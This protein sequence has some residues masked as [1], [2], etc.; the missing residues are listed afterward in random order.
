[1]K[2]IL[3]HRLPGLVR[4]SKH[5]LALL[6]LATLLPFAFFPF[7]CHAQGVITT[8]AGSRFIGFAGDG[9][10]A[11]SALLDTPTG[12]ALDTAGNLYIADS[13]SDRVRKVLFASTPFFSVVPGSLSFAAAA[14]EAAA[15]VQQL[16]LNSSVAGLPW[17]ASVIA[18]G[19]WLSLS[20]SSGQMPATVSVSA[21]ATSLASFTHQASIEI[22]APAAMPSLATILVT[23]T[24]TEALPAS[25]AVEPSSLSFQVLAGA[26]AP[27]AQSLRIENTGSGTIGWMAKAEPASGN[28]LA[29]SATS[30]NVSAGTPVS[31][32]INVNPAGLAAG[33]HSGS[34][35]V[36]SAD[37][38]RASP[39]R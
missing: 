35:T 7:P 21:D 26:S 20:S 30:G 34:I 33:S 24:V 8:V 5:P 2:R 13:R 12:V 19:S 6:C 22:S 32:Q 11:T 16:T 31:L 23:F 39:C 36:G 14:G 15:G 18:G 27:P 4:R 17:Q 37:T 9:G 29:I 28:W 38:N 25:L 1:M 3:R 10:P